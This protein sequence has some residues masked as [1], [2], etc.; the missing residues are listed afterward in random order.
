MNRLYAS[1]LRIY[2]DSGEVQKITYFDK[3]DGIFY[4]I[5]QIDEKEKWISGFQWNIIN[6]PKKY[7]YIKF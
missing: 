1:E 3:P 7:N 2:L 5:D 6:K 4:P